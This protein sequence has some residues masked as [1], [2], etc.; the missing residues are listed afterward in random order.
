MAASEMRP[1]RAA[2]WRWR[3]RATFAFAS[4][5]PLA[6]LLL[7]C[8]SITGLSD[9]EKVECT[10][11]RCSEAGFDGPLIDSGQDVRTDV[12]TVPPG[13]PATFAKWRMPNYDAGDGGVVDNPQSFTRDGDARDVL[14]D[15]V[16][17]LRW[18]SFDSGD[19]GAGEMTLEQAKAFCAGQPGGWR[20]PTRIELVSLLDLGLGRPNR[21][22]PA[23]KDAKSATY[24]TVSEH[25]SIP[26]GAT[27]AQRDGQVWVVSFAPG[28]PSLPLPP[29]TVQAPT[30]NAA[31]R[32]VGGAK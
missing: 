13:D 2:T 3:R 28:Q 19:A 8:E 30:A 5:L 18:L 29:L 24:W 21:F 11:L 23:F 27:T 22:P 31:V 16:T 4:A 1:A 25:W 15:Q 14:I 12:V 10:N 26:A 6:L 9:Y 7:A 17:R 32:C 20:V